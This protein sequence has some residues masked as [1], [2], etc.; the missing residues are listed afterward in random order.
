VLKHLNKTEMDFPAV[1]MACKPRVMA[2][3]SAF[4]VHLIWHGM[5]GSTYT[6]GMW[7]EFSGIMGHPVPMFAWD[8][9]EGFPNAKVILTVRR[10][11]D[12]WDTLV[13]VAEKAQTSAIGIH[14]GP[15]TNGTAIMMGE[16]LAKMWIWGVPRDGVVTKKQF[17]RRYHQHNAKIIHGVPKDQLL[18]WN[19]YE[20]PSWD[21]I[22]KF[23]GEPVPTEAFPRLSNDEL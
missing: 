19:M 6:A 2:P 15:P 18:V 14:H 11:E 22:A 8:M 5:Q 3:C 10:A 7:G 1:P 13:R 21:E 9:L 16:A 17:L 20:N 12:V 23:I 4:L